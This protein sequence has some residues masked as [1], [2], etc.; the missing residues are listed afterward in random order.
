MMAVV[1]APIGDRKVGRRSAFLPRDVTAVVR[2]G[3]G[4]IPWIAWWARRGR[5]H[6]RSQDTDGRGF[7][8]PAAGTARYAG[9]SLAARASG[10]PRLR[11]LLLPVLLRVELPELDRGLAHA[12]R[13]VVEAQVP[14]AVAIFE[15]DADARPEGLL[16]VSFAAFDDGDELHPARGVRG[17]VHGNLLG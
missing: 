6:P 11:W 3:R 2:L 16:V 4:P 14:G 5:G 7:A 8:A 10:T 1:P 13:D 17:G 15:G 9:S 12:G